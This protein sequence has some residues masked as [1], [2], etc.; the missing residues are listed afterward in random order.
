M[1]DVKFPLPVKEIVCVLDVP[2]PDTVKGTVRVSLAKLAM[3]AASGNVV[4]AGVD[5]AEAGAGESEPPPPH[6]AIARA[7]AVAAAK[8][9]AIAKKVVGMGF[10]V[11]RLY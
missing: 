7:V 4:V 3:A 8:R 11:M 10:T 2:V 5:G 1:L 9:E 6:A